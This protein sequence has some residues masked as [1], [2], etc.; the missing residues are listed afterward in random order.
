MVRFN[1]RTINT[2]QRFTISGTTID[3]HCYEVIFHLLQSSFLFRVIFCGDSSI[4]VFG[5]SQIILNKLFLMIRISFQFVQRH[6]QK[7]VEDRTFRA[8]LFSF[9][10]FFQP[11]ISLIYI[12][13][14]SI[15]NVVNSFITQNI[16]YRRSTFQMHKIRSI[17]NSQIKNLHQ[18]IKI[19]LVISRITVLYIIQERC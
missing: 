2:L 19:L 4:S 17:F 5:I 10:R 7:I 1:F 3:E 8:T 13:I 12:Y 6:I 14:R 9:Q 11:S 15:S 18:F 16:A